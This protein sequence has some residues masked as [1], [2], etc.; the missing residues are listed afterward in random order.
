[1][2]TRYY[3]KKIQ[4][5]IMR[6]IFPINSREL[7][8]A[9][10]GP[11]VFA[12][13]IPKA[14]TNVLSQMLNQIPCIAPRWTYAIDNSIPGYFKQLYY[15][16][17]GQV[18][19]AHMYRSQE[20]VD[21]LYGNGFRIL[22]IIRDLRDIATSNAFYITY[23]DKPHRLHSYFTSLPNDSERLMASIIGID[24]RLLKDGSRSKSI[25]EHAEAYLPW[26]DEP[27][28]LTIRFEDLIGSSG[29]GRDKRQID[30]VNSVLKHIDIK[31]SES[32]IKELV[33]KIFFSGSRTFRKGKIGDWKNHFTEEH[34]RVFKEVAGK[35]LIKLGYENGYDW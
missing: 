11:K 34:K 2:N 12:N 10:Y 31:L 30:T 18:V 25:G 14:G 4:Y 19:T 24:G 33:T 5:L 15:V 26:L 7:K 28:C 27:N 32:E 23:I 6:H 35:A 8:A 3:K 17:K 29:G 16:K 13:S 9:R 22:F 1:M 20:L 21:F